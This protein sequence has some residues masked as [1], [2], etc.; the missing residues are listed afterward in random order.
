LTN[1]F[2][3]RR[4]VARVGGAHRLDRDWR[5]TTDLYLANLNLSSFPPRD[6]HLVTLA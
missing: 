5:I 3:R 4:D 6:M 2:D 1:L